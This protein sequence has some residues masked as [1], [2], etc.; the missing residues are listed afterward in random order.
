M[1][2]FK[3]DVTFNRVKGNSEQSAKN[4]MEASGFI[5][6]DYSVKEGFDA[7]N[8]EVSTEASNYL[9]EQVQLYSKVNG[10]AIPN[11]TVFRQI[12]LSRFNKTKLKN[13]VAEIY[14]QLG[15]KTKSGNVVIKSVYQSTGVNHAKSI[16]G[17]FSMRVDNTNN[18]FGNPFSSVE[19]EIQKG[20]IRTKDTQ[21]SVEKYIEW[22]IS[23][24]TD[25]KPAQH[26][27]IRDWLM[28]GTL[29]NKPIVYYKE[30]REPSH[31]TA[32]DYLINK[33]EWNA[34]PNSDM[35]KE[36]DA[37]GLYQS[38]GTRTLVTSKTTLNVDIDLTREN[39]AEENTVNLFSEDENV[40]RIVIEN[41]GLNLTAIDTVVLYKDLGIATSAYTKLGKFAE[42]I[43]MV[44]RS[45]SRRSSGG[46]A[47]WESLVRKGMA[48]RVGDRYYFIDSGPV[49]LNEENSV[50]LENIPSMSEDVKQMCN[51]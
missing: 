25:I 26:K 24:K 49:N 34:V 40:G 9:G 36:T 13:T 43:G 6:P 16:G 35:S 48:E 39:L 47:L 46:D 14:S 29:K 41:D 28:S 1:S 21:D 3:C 4:K 10:F 8:Q 20:L 23:P 42:S 45:D 12:D 11:T 30:L 33:Y 7:A 38:I 51:A 50:T 19:S 17:V 31:A 32:L 18:H 15:T 44:F 22:V 2:V 37:P 27:F 5:G